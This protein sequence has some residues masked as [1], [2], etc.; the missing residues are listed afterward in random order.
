M[1]E[2]ASAYGLDCASTNVANGKGVVSHILDR[3]SVGIILLDSAHRVVFANAPAQSL[4]TSGKRLR[5]DSSIY[6]S[7]TPAPTQLL[8]ELLESAQDGAA[9]A[10]TSIPYPTDSSSLMLLISS[11][12]SGEA[13]QLGR[14][15]QDATVVLFVWDPARPTDI[16]L[17]WMIKAYGLTL[18][19]AKVATSASLGMTVAG[20]AQRLGLSPNTIKTHLRKVFAKTGTSRLAE[21]TRF[22]ASVGAVR[23]PL[24]ATESSRGALTQP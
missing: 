1:T 14:A 19:E 23:D 12:R 11:L 16:P 15:L 18:A 13:A 9:T 2:I 5:L 17:A 7:F 6:D 8:G 24:A 22:I 10:A 4:V 20:M 3:F 21:L